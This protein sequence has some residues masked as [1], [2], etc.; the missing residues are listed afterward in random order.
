MGEVASVSAARE[1]AGWQYDL[2]VTYAE[3]DREWVHGYLVPA[4]GLP[5]ER[6]QTPKTSGPARRWSSSSAGRLPR[7]GSP[8]S[9]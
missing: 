5:P 8:R 6:L 9:S 7:A 2:S 3:A 4:L 1:P